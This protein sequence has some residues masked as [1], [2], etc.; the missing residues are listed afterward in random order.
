MALTLQSD[1]LFQMFSL[2]VLQKRRIVEDTTTENSNAFICTQ[3]Y[4]KK[5]LLYVMD[6]NG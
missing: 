1:I 4:C 3:M 5:V 6:G 2:L